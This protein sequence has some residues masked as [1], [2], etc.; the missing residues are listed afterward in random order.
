MIRFIQNFIIF[1]LVSLVTTLWLPQIPFSSEPISRSF[2]RLS[3]GMTLSEVKTQIRTQEIEDTVKLLEEERFFYL[4]SV[5]ARPGIEGVYCLFYRDRLYQIVKQYNAN[6]T[7]KI[8]WKDFVSG[9]LKQYGKASKEREANIPIGEELQRMAPFA[10]KTVKLNGFLKLNRGKVW[11]DSATSL[12]IFEGKVSFMGER[13]YHGPPPVHPDK[14]QKVETHYIVIFSDNKTFR[15]VPK[16][17]VPPREK[18]REGP[19]HI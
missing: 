7:E 10:F 5:S 14:R 9:H 8:R 19:I 4:P 16:K 17:E 18:E 12:G 11:K 15:K 13:R 2:G 6:Y 3:L 1:F